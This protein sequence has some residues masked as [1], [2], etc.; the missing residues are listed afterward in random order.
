MKP[1][2]A[3]PLVIPVFI[4][5]AGCP[6]HCIFCNQKQIANSAGL[7]DPETE[8]KKAI[9]SFLPYK[10]QRNSVE[11]A[12][13]GG[14]FLGLPKHLIL[15]LLETAQEYVSEGQID[16]IRFST[17][18]DT[19]DR[20]RLDM[21]APFAV[22]TIEIGVQSMTDAV[23]EKAGRGHTRKDTLNA[24]ELLKNRGLTTGVQVMIG[25]PEE[26]AEQMIEGARLLACMNPDIARIYPLLVLK[27][28]ALAKDFSQGV[29]TPISLEES[30]IIAKQMYLAFADWGV[31]VIR[32]GLQA[33]EMLNDDSV[34][35]SGPWHPAFGHL[36]YSELM[37]DKAV[38]K[39]EKKLQSGQKEILLKVHP[40]SESRLR[41]NR[42]Q[43]L[44][45]LETGYRNACIT[46][47]RDDHVPLNDVSV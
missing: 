25:L 5:H 12:F 17:R 47:C 23:L 14:S 43:N 35:L 31:D 40:K 45:R 42:N 10:G 39:I 46:I 32:M 19:I 34:V 7:A 3:R 36:V 11:L 2:E 1:L 28:T 8:I 16:G 30:V 41:G 4:P 20:D 21:I 26:T 37:Y 38:K 15:S 9:E 29:Y 33:S 24:L 44:K 18:P 13:F 6:H 27:G 22:S